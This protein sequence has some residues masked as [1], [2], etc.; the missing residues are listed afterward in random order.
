[1]K[2]FAKLFAAAS[3]TAAAVSS[4]A[5]ADEASYYINL[6]IGT[7]FGQEVE[8]DINGVGFDAE[9]RTTFGGG[10]GFGVD[11]EN[12]IRLE[13]KLIHSTANIDS[14]TVGGRKYDVDESGSGW[15]SGVDL[16]YDFSNDTKYTP[17]VGVGVGFSW[18][19]D[20]VAYGFSA[21]AGVSYEAAERIDVYA[22][23]SYGFTPEQEINGVD[24]DS[25]GELGAIAGVRFA[26]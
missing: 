13:S 1:M 20:E 5:M 18:A 6:G 23:I 7:G 4:P 19:E 2:L 15:G 10:I 9:G 21:V 16:E 11:F 12:N 26:F 17:Y 24:Y 14:V 3:I 22:E 25:S 8:G